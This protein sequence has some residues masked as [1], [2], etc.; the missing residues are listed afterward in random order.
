MAFRAMEE[1]P[2]VVWQRLAKRLKQREGGRMIQP[3]IRSDPS[4]ST[5][6]ERV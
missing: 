6:Q 2:L 4:H 1:T 3:V 5:W